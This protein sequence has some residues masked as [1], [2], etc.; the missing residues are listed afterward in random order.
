MFNCLIWLA[1]LQTYRRRID[2]VLG[3]LTFG[4]NSVDKSSPYCWDRKKKNVS[5]VI[6]AIFLLREELKPYASVR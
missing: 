4:K 1:L 5:F 3:E 2:L 6:S